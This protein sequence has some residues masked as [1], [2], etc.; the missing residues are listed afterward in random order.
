MPFIDELSNGEVLALIEAHKLMGRGIGLVDVH[1]LGAVLNMEKMQL[2]TRDKRLH[3]IA[4]DLG[5]AFADENS[6]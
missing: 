2:W 3:G 1:I 5:I 6:A 4:N